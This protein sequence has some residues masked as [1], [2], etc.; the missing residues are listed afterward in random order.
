MYFRFA[1]SSAMIINIHQ[2]TTCQDLDFQK[3]QVFGH[4]ETRLTEVERLTYCG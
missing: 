3:S 2:L 1:V 4:A